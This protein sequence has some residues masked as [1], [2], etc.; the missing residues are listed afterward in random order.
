MKNSKPFFSR[1]KKSQAAMEFLMTYGWA[2]II[3][4]AATAALLYFGVFNPGKVLGDKLMM[5]NNFHALSSK[6]ST[7]GVEIAVEYVGEGSISN[8]TLYI[9]GLCTNT[10]PIT[11]GNGENKVVKCTGSFKK[12][13]QFNHEFYLNYTSYGIDSSKQG[14]IITTV[15]P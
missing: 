14:Q 7:T 1:K 3:I 11:L 5:P 10:T 15:E 8:L 2:I 12:G 4:L 9:P 13:D 6:V